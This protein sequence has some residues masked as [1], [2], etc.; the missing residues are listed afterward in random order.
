MATSTLSVQAAAKTM[1]SAA[2]V[3]G[4]KPEGRL[5]RVAGPATLLVPVRE[6]MEMVGAEYL[7]KLQLT[8]EF[9]ESESSG[10]LRTVLYG[11]DGKPKMQANEIIPLPKILQH[12]EDMPRARAVQMRGHHTKDMDAENPRV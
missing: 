1:N 6:A 7:E 10:C 12:I 8:V 3:R 5:L 9:T 2:G 4:A 11:L